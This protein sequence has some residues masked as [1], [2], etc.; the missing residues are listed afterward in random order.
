[1]GQQYGVHCR[2]AVR[3]GETDPPVSADGAPLDGEEVL[4]DGNLLADGHDFFALGA[5]DVSPDGRWLAYSTD[6]SGDERFTLRVKDLSTGKVLADEV[7]NT[8]YGTAWSADASVLF[9]VTVDDAWR[10]NRVWRPPSAPARANVGGP[11]EDDE[12]FWVGVE[13]TR[14]ETFILLDIHSKITSEV[15][16]I[17]AGNPTGEPAVIAPRRQGVEY[18]VEHHGHRFLILHNDGAEDFALAYTSADA[19]GDWV[20]LIEHSPGTRLESVDAFAHHLVVSRSN[21]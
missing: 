18:A 13:L 21:G 17:P 7:P 19:P 4:L 2:R 15:R 5:F 20:P 8:F 14:S 12:R 6:F 11:Q 3:D 10:P 9:Y 16:V 1:V